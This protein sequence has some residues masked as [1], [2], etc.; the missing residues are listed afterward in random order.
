L[1]Q[2][3]RFAFSLQVT[4]R[5]QSRSPKVASILLIQNTYYSLQIF[6]EH[7]DVNLLACYR[8]L[9]SGE[10]PGQFNRSDLPWMEKIR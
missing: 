4:Y 10:N 9:G 3:A 5:H 7:S 1:G 6:F 2:A 8:R